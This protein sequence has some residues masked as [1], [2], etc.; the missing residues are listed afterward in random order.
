MCCG[1]ST[2]FMISCFVSNKKALD[3]DE[4]LQWCV[5]L[6]AR[7]VFIDAY[8]Y[9]TAIF[10]PELSGVNCFVYNSFT[11]SFPHP[12]RHPFSCKG[13]T[14]RNKFHLETMVYQTKLPHKR[15][16]LHLI[17][18]G[19]VYHIAV[20]KRHHALGMSFPYQSLCMYFGNS[21]CT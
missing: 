13:L 14:C 2:L 17:H 18:R 11:F 21:K 8:I 19:L 1:S 4:Y 3:V 5:L 9:N 6:L 12:S 15:I 16:L 10:S 20:W 7:S